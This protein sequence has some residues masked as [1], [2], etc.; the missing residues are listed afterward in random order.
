MPQQFGEYRLLRLMGEGGMAQ[1]W[2]AQR[3][4]LGGPMSCAVKI[5]R[6]CHADDPHYREMFQREARLS[7]ALSGHGN[8]VT[9]FDMGVHEGRAYLA[10]ELVD[11]VTLAELSRRVGTPWPV[12]NAVYVVAGVLRALCHIHGHTIDG[13]PQGI[14]HRDVTPH[15]VMISSRGEVKLMDFGIA[16]RSDA[17]PCLGG[18]LGK[19]AYVP[20]EQVEGDPDQR[21]DLYAAGALLFELLDGRRF[22]WHCA[23]EDAFFLEIYRDRVPTLRRKDVPAAVMAVLRGLLQ[24]Y[25]EHR[26]ATAAEA[27][28]MLEAWPGFRWA[29]SE[30]EVA[31]AVAVGP[32]PKAPLRRTLPRLPLPRL[33]SVEP[34]ARRL[35]WTDSQAGLAANDAVDAVHDAVHERGASCWDATSPRA[36]A[37]AEPITLEDAEPVLLEELELDSAAHRR[38]R[39]ASAPAWAVR[40]EPKEPQAEELEP[41]VVAVTDELPSPDELATRLLPAA[42]RNPELAVEPVERLVTR[43]HP[44]A[45][46]EQNVP[47]S[48]TSA[49]IAITQP[50]PSRHAPWAAGTDPIA[51]RLIR[52]EPGAPIKRRRT[53]SDG[54]PIPRTGSVT[55]RPRE[56]AAV[57]RAAS[58]PMAEAEAGPEAGLVTGE[59][60]TDDGLDTFGEP[61]W[62]VGSR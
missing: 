43:R 53:G 1:V 19:L 30:L 33:R 16:Q 48:R 4:T 42:E 3:Q 62:R 13:E 35:P 27:L 24:P 11:G 55:P 51:Q 37:D 44:G 15:N 36:S 32:R 8:V 10:M 38:H 47:S 59:I 25:R 26:I 61:V 54:L 14:V 52:A 58:S 31:Y 23:D 56:S 41:V 7:L 45:P 29:L 40:A 21:A 9:V 39:T 22:R 5:I 17:E 50:T 6:P 57:H 49:E 18:A 12:A 46:A 34:A 2:S 60:V 28:R 20:R